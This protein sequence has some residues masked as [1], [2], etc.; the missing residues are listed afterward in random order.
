MKVENSDSEGEC[1][2]SQ[3]LTNSVQLPHLN[4]ASQ[5]QSKENI[6]DSWASLS[7]N[8]STQKFYNIDCEMFGYDCSQSGLKQCY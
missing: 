7:A 6:Y 5:N 8:Q 1:L 4:I 2:L 3:L